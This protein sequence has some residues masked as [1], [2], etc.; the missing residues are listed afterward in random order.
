MSNPE[1]KLTPKPGDSPSRP[2]PPTLRAK[3]DLDEEAEEVSSSKAAN[4]VGIVM[5]VA[6]VVLGGFFWTS[7][8][9]SKVEEKTKAVAAAK[10]A[11]DEALVDSLSKVRADSIYAAS[12]DSIKAYEAKHPKPKTATPP[13]ASAGAGGAAAGGGAA[14]EPPPPPSKFGIDVGSYL[15]QDRASAEQGKLQGITSLPAQ[16]VPK[17]EDG[18]T[19]YHV[20]IGEFTNRKDAEKKANELIV[21]QT[22]RE[23]TVTKLK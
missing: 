6:I 9:R 22:I 23:A 19:A 16:V 1:D 7:F 14:A 18:G 15:T 5:L 17:S 4:V 11:A 2:I 21:A 3:I 20:V 8:Q 10:A 12:Q 13:T